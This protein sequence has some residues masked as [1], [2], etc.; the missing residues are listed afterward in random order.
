MVSKRLM[1]VWLT[2]DGLLLI[3]GLISVILPQIWRAP[4][5][6]MNMV[7]SSAELTAGTVLG[8]ALIIT[9][10][11]SIVAIA[12]K[13]HV[14][15]G[16]V[17]LNYFLLLDAAGIIIIGSFVWWYT[18]QERA[19]FHQLWL[20]APTTTR[21]FLQDKFLC[22]GYF[23]GSD[24][25]GVGGKFCVSQEFVQSLPVDDVNRFCVT[26]IT[27]F[28]DSTLNNIFTTIYG[29]MA[30]VICFLLASLCVIRKRQEDDRFMKIDA[31]RG[32]HGFV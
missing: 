26:P 24:L 30:I 8:V 16:F 6:L 7:I 22:C 18:L 3:S 1:A 14:T 4:N 20:Q 13:S 21:I 29:F 12:Q 2:L 28:A 32:G 11:L 9:F 5:V 10:L 31:K 15:R 27:K 25:V 23:N 19:N 17:I